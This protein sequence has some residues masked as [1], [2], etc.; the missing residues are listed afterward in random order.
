MECGRRNT[1]STNTEHAL[2]CEINLVTPQVIKLGKLEMM[3]WLDDVGAGYGEVMWW[4]CIFI[5]KFTPPSV[6]FTKYCR[7]KARVTC[8][9]QGKCCNCRT[10]CSGACDCVGNWQEN[11][12]QKP[13]WRKDKRQ[14]A[15][16]IQQPQGCYSPASSIQLPK[17]RILEALP[18]SSN[19]G[20]SYDPLQ[21]HFSREKK[22]PQD[23]G[24]DTPL[25]SSWSRSYKPQKLGRSW[26]PQDSSPGKGQQPWQSGSPAKD[27]R[28]R[29]WILRSTKVKDCPTQRWRCL[30]PHRFTT[31]QGQEWKRWG[32]GL[33]RWS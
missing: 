14:E 17:A 20:T 24:H 9:I 1:Y 7:V 23:S 5:N 25:D 16:S 27:P 13:L 19:T 29:N 32:Q 33:T 6:R 18:K 10:C 11:T 12:G 8:W 4:S 22:L 28:K 21:N 15:V 2:P 3:I 30:L 26:S 31:R